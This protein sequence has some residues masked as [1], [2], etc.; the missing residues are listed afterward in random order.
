MLLSLNSMVR[1][2]DI[3][4]D[5]TISTGRD[6]DVDCAEDTARL[7]E[8]VLELMSISVD[9][10]DEGV[11]VGEGDGGDEERHQAGREP[12]LAADSMRCG[13]GGAVQRRHSDRAPSI[14]TRSESESSRKFRAAKTTKV[15]GERLYKDNERPLLP[16]ICFDNSH[17]IVAWTHARL[18]MQ[19]FGERFRFR[20]EL[21]VI[22]SI[23]MLVVMMSVGLLVLGMS[24]N[25]IETFLAPWF[26]QTLLSVTMCIGFNVMIMYRGAGVN[27]ALRA[28]NHSLCTHSLRLHRKIETCHNALL[29]DTLHGEERTQ[30]QEEL[31]SLESVVEKLESMRSVIET[32]GELKPY[33]VFGFVA[34]NSLTI[35]ILTTAVT[36][37]GIIFSLLFSSESQAVTSVG[38]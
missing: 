36:F 5:V 27:D 21:Y 18:V 9:L 3:A 35:S 32:N 38:L 33:R 22:A 25:R 17:N 16:R 29:S 10:S 7:R 34:E 2:T 23:A 26:L 6:T 14:S 28:H 1:E 8:H 37:Y 24:S 20:L 19:N 4:V 13:G 15:L 11:S 30:V 31:E 12:V